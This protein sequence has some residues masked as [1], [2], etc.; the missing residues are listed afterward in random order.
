MRQNQPN[1]WNRNRLS[2]N[3]WGPLADF[4]TEF[5]RIFDDFLGANE[6]PS[7]KRGSDWVPACDIQEAEGH[8]LISLEVP[9]IS[10]DQIRL[11]I[12]DH[13]LQV[14]GERKAET[15]SEKDGRWYSERN[16]GRFERSFALPE[17]VATDRMEAHYENGVLQILV[18]K[19]EVAKPREIKIQQ[20]SGSGLFN[21]LLGKSPVNAN[22]ESNERH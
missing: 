2:E 4:R 3:R 12:V 16:Y 8:F 5:D 7:E 11:E 20:G 6:R 13:R 9:G 10:K 14:S 19:S 22:S 18:P 15:K 21:R 1:P 17:N